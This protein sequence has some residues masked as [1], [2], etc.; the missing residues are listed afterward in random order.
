M[1]YRSPSQRV[2]TV[3]AC[4]GV[5]LLL[6]SVYAWS[7]LAAD[8]ETRGLAAWQTQL[9]FGLTI[10]VFASMTLPAGR[11]L[12]RLS[13]RTLAMAGGM[14]YAAGHLL[15]GAFGASFMWLVIGLGLVAATGIG[16]AYMA[17]LVAC[18]RC[19]PERRGLV[20][21]IAVAGFGAG[22]IL[23]SHAAEWLL[24]LGLSAPEVLQRAGLVA[25]GIAALLASMISPPAEPRT[26]QK[27]IPLRPMLQSPTFRLAAV[28]IFC[29]CFAGLLLVGSLRQLGAALS[30]A[31]TLQAITAFAAG[32]ISGRLLW[33]WAFDRWGFGVIPTNLALGAITALLLA[34]TLNAPAAFVLAAAV[35]GLAFGGNFSL[36]AAYLGQVFGATRL[37]RIYPFVFMSYGA[38]AILGPAFGGLL[39]DLT[40]SPL[41][42]PVMAALVAGAG[43]AV[44]GAS[45]L[46][47]RW[48]EPTVAPEQ[49][50]V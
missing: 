27:H 28:G 44:L 49:V 18:A 35:A 4:A 34:G 47:S 39:R 15:G 11:L 29:G 19:Y 41:A 31:V 37:P 21:G 22:A 9:I 24:G 20:S 3:A 17:A 32:N 48:S 2:T 13:A 45:Y 6:G 46:R 26:A 1:E 40:G 12:Q 7:V 42:L 50:R 25:G 23:H 8:L 14:L 16:C 43:A 30:A 5:Q 36:Y 33:G 38:S 10:G